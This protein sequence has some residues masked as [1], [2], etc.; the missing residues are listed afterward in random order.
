MPSFFIKQKKTAK[1]IAVS[2]DLPL[3]LY[4]SGRSFRN[5]VVHFRSFFVT[6]FEL[7]L[8]NTPT[9]EQNLIL[10]NKKFAVTSV[11]SVTKK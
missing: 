2:F 6:I 7:S 11:I 4:G 1:L 9:N 3:I 5:P 8:N 10:Y